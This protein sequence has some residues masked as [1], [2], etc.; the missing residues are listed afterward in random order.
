MTGAKDITRLCFSSNLAGIVANIK[1]ERNIYC[2]FLFRNRVYR[3][4]P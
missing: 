3:M 2:L 1:I 4:R